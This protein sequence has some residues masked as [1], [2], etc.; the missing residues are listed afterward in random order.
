M[1]QENICIFY[2]EMRNLQ[3]KVKTGRCCGHT[4]MESLVYIDERQHF[5]LAGVEETS[6]G[7]WHLVEGWTRSGLA[8]LE[9]VE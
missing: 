7:M 9:C 6:R 8:L 5:R 3:Y 2:L 1:F 4:E